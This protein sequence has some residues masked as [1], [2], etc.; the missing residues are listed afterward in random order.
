MLESKG[1]RGARNACRAWPEIHKTILKS[2]YKHPSWVDYFCDVVAGAAWQDALIG[3]AISSGRAQQG[4]VIRVVHR[5]CAP[6][7]ALARTTSFV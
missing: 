3:K 2:D 1:R 4:W 7:L 6:V 5:A